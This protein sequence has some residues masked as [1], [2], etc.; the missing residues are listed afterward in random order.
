MEGKKGK[1]NKK[2]REARK[3]ESL[4]EGKR[5]RRRIGGLDV[6]GRGERG[7]RKG[8][9]KEERKEKVRGILGCIKEGKGVKRK[10]E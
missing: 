4:T 7:R 10:E 5:G 3:S 9:I 2:E 1:R 8:R 6:N